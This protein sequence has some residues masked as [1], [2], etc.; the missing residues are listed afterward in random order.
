MIRVPSQCRQ[1]AVRVLFGCR[2]SAIRV[3]SEWQRNQD[4]AGGQRGTYGRPEEIS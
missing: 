2:P 4:N 3:P 1:S